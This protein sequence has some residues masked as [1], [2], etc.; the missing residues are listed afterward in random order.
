MGVFL[1]TLLL[2]PSLKGA[3]GLISGF[4]DVI[5][6]AEV[7]NWPDAALRIFSK[8]EGFAGMSTLYRG[9]TSTSF[10]VISGITKLYSSRASNF[11][12]AEGYPAFQLEFRNWLTEWSIENF[13][14]KR[15]RSVLLAAPKEEPF[16]FIFDNSDPS[17]AIAEHLQKEFPTRI[18]AIYLR[19][20]VFRSMPAGT[21][22]F[23]TAWDIAIQE[24][25]A[26]RLTTAVAQTVVEDLLEEKNF[27]RIIPTFAYCP[28]QYSPC[29][30]A[31]PEFQARC[32]SLTQALAAKITQACIRR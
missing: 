4:D 1:S 11:M 10:T 2:F 14:M 27:E 3:T 32:Q 12:T 29:D 17:L 6:Q 30:K 18:A 20:T 31:A 13:K 21:K 24:N 8:D 19:Q 7:Q 5:R 16:V 23:I 25:A 26:H 28:K 22:T 9:M 15:I